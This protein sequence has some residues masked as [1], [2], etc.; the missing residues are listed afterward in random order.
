ME[1]YE[2]MLLGYLRTEYMSADMR[3]EPCRLHA[4]IREQIHKYAS[5]VIA[6]KLTITY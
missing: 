6:K 2:E 5:V 4:V 3:F 1:E